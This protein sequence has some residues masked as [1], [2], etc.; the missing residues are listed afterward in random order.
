MSYR[1]KIT[2]GSEVTVARLGVWEFGTHAFHLP[3]ASNEWQDAGSALSLSLILSPVCCSIPASYC[4][5]LR[6]LAF[7]AGVDPADP[8]GSMLK[9]VTYALFSSAVVLSFSWVSSS[10]NMQRLKLADLSSCLLVGLCYTTGL[11]LSPSGVE[12]QERTRLASRNAYPT[13]L[14]R[15]LPAGAH[16]KEASLPVTRVSKRKPGAPL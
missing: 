11:T 15:T 2:P 6:I 8:D 14:L 7:M 12:Q 1:Q 5:R 3:R 9:A 16:R 4:L 13:R 10:L